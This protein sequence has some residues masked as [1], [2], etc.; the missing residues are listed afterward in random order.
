M[1][2]LSPGVVVRSVPAS[3]PPPDWPA[4]SGAAAI[5]RDQVHLWRLRLDQPARVVSDLR[6]TL[7]DDE[8]GRAERAATA[9]AGGQFVVARGALRTVLASYLGR[10]PRQLAFAYGPRG[11]PTLVGDDGLR[12]NVA[13]SHGLAL[14]AVARARDLG[15]DLERVRPLPAAEAIARRF[16][17]PRERGAL[18]ALPPGRRLDAFLSL[19]TRKEAY[20]KATGGGLGWGRALAAVDLEDGLDGWTVRELTPARSFRAA[21]VVEGAGWALATWRWRPPTL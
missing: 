13:H 17:S 2:V 6:A 4:R 19:W 21:L 12:F 15:V 7:S 9:L 5:E 14:L 3:R 8:R 16:F 18:D 10:D 20:L 1:L 11:K